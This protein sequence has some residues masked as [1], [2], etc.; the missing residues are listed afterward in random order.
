[1]V[2]PW[3]LASHGIF[4]LICLRTCYW[5]RWWYG[6]PGWCPLCKQLGISKCTRSVFF[7]RFCEC[8]IIF[9]CIFWV[10]PPPSHCGKW[11]FRGIP[12]LKCNNPGGDWNPRRR[13][14]PMYSLESWWMDRTAMSGAVL[15]KV[16]SGVSWF[17]AT[18]EIG[19]RNT[20]D[21]HYIARKG[22]PDIHIG[23]NKNMGFL[24]R[25]VDC[26]RDRFIQGI[27]KDVPRSQRTPLWESPINKPYIVGI[28]GLS[29][30]IIWFICPFLFGFPRESFGICGPSCI[31]L[32][33]G[34]PDGLI[35]CE[36]F[37][38][39]GLP[40]Q[41]THQL[42]W[43]IHIYYIYIYVHSYIYSNNICS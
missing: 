21:T 1:M 42:Y 15:K 17:E 33:S 37:R 14:N 40:K 27:G 16:I 10:V 4:D 2:C 12:Y 9:S 29:S 5:S 36:A 25:I 23:Y 28:Y 3:Y 13:D 31:Q 11:R 20:C 39:W 19:L 26:F 35:G 22:H 8:F 7:F 30:R 38:C 18:A 32:D 34:C 43:Y 41:K 24:P 6:R